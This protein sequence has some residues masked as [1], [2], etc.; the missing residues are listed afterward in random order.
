MFLFRLLRRL[1]TRTKVDESDFCSVVLLLRE[2]RFFTQTELM[3]AGR[4]GFGKSF[5]GDEDPMYFVVQNGPITLIKAGK[6]AMHVLH[7]RQP[8]LENK[9]EVAKTIVL[10]TQREAWLAHTA[11]A[12]IDLL[13]KDV[14]N[15]EAYTTLARFAR[16]LVDRNCIAVFLPKHNILLTND[17][18]AEEWLD[19]TI[20][21]KHKF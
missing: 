10:K 15:A 12:S 2:W 3:E 16:N 19:D 11:W 5:S 18:Q 9:E 8:Y 1:F 6:H 14:P 17:G 20:R 7:Q 13:N 21:G 4:L